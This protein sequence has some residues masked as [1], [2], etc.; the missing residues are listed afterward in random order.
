[1]AN[2]LS[3]LG[4]GAAGG[5][6]AKAVQLDGL[7][8]YIDLGAMFTS[9][10]TSNLLN[11]FTFGVTFK[12]AST[13]GTLDVLLGGPN[14]G[15]I[16]APFLIYIQSAGMRVYY[17]KSIPYFRAQSTAIGSITADT[18]F[19]LATSWSGVDGT[20][21]GQIYLDGV[22][23]SSG[24]NGDSGVTTIGSTESVSIAQNSATYFEYDI[25]AIWWVDAT[26][27]GAQVTAVDAYLVAKDYYGLL[28]YLQ[29]IDS[30]AVVIPVLSTDNLA[31]DGSG[32]LEDLAAIRNAIPYNT[33]GADLID[34]PT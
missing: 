22:N 8:Q 31:G 3:L 30:N 21:A 9:R 13:L 2:N 29:V 20:A 6:M 34:I 32:T 17:Q 28:A 14:V 11:P 19:R 18:V 33:S 23:S 27:T 25:W 4:A 5:H 16:R 7:T 12:T 1:M 26:L 15:G 10:V 24:F